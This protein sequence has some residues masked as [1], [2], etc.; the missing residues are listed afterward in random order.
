[1]ELIQKQ[2]ETQKRKKRKKDQFW[3][4]CR[5][6]APHRGLVVISI[7]CAFVVGGAF[8]GG[9]ATLLP[10]MQV[11]IKNGSVQDWVNRQ[12]VE[13]RLHVRLVDNTHEVRIGGLDDKHDPGLKTGQEL[14]PADG[15]GDE[16]AA[17]RLL[18]ELS[19]P[20]RTDVQIFAGGQ[21]LDIH[22]DDTS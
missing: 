12:V 16:A 13:K 8:T 2:P 1:M 22:L 18:S 14:T 15:A 20:N 6:L 3:R 7:I 21:P 5:Y 10:I 19:D 9:L 17:S 4:A 11:L